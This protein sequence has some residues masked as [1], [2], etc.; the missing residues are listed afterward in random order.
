[1]PCS[2]ENIVNLNAVSIKYKTLSYTF[3]PN[4]KLTFIIKQK[5]HALMM[6]P[7]PKE[8]NSTAVQSVRNPADRE[9]L[10]LSLLQSLAR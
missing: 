7:P 8:E 4:S 9:K 5:P 2:A 10:L 6:I 3:L 1:M